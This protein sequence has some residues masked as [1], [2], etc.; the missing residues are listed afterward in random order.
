[1]KRFLLTNSSTRLELSNLGARITRIQ[2]LT[3]GTWLDVHEYYPEDLPYQSNRK[4]TGATIGPVCGRIKQAHF[5]L[6]G[7]RY[8]FKPNEQ[9]N[10]LHSGPDGLHAVQWETYSKENSV[11]FKTK[12]S[13]EDDGF[14]GNQSYQVSY[15]LTQQGIRIDY[16]V[17]SDKDTHINLCN[18]AYFNLNQDIH[19]NQ[20]HFNIQADQVVELDR[21]K[22]PTGN[23]INVEGTDYDLN[24]SQPLGDRIF[25]HCFSV[26][27]NVELKAQAIG[28]DSGI[29]L[30]VKTN[31]PGI[32]F[33]SG[34]NKFFCFEC[35][36]FPDATHHSDFPTTLLKHDEL[37]EY[38]CE[39][40]F[41]HI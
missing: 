5:A 15:T 27:E 14:P 4:Y 17:E 19:L 36:H 30:E 16:K 40:N 37:Y 25:D 11:M 8:S 12:R 6:N 10:L 35:Q 24:K 23:L 28:L 22:L 33:Y 41:S 26:K 13:F 39:Y 3:R 9:G 18:H 34:N 29:N 2:I 7:Q 21:N 1:M 38:F 32:Q 20:H 31:Q